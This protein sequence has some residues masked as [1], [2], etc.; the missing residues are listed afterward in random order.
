M[1]RFDSA[2]AQAAVSIADLDPLSEDEEEQL[3]LPLRL[4]GCGLPYMA[5]LA[6]AAWLGSWLQRLA[7]VVR[8]GGEALRQF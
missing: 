7:G 1:E 5:A 4:G 2:V 8:G 3:R 6:P